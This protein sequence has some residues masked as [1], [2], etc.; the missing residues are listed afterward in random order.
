MKLLFV[1][2]GRD[3]AGGAAYF[4]SLAQAMAEAGHHV[5][6]LADG[7]QYVAHKLDEAGITWHHARFRNVL[8]PSAN[9]VPAQ[10]IRRM[11]PDWLLNGSAGKEYW[12][13]VIHGR[14]QGLPV[15]LFR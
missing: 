2:T 6:V 1:S 7:D 13:L 5:E 10:T 12:P 9:R 4:L 8:T 15:A 14:M 3:R 11:R